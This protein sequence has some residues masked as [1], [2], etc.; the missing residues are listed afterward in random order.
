MLEQVRTHLANGQKILYYIYLTPRRTTLCERVL[1]EEG[2]LGD[3]TL[4]EY[5]FDC[6][7]L[8]DDLLSL[9]LTM[10]FRELF[11]VH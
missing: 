9:E 2:I 6:V 1:E 5:H 3:V 7:P 10:S 11:L 8:D 4:G